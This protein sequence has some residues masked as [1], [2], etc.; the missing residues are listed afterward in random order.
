M[1]DLTLIL[2]HLVI[3]IAALVA[4]AHRHPTFNQRVTMTQLSWLLALAP[5]SAFILL[6]LR[7]PQINAGEVLVW[8]WNW[9]P[10]LG[11]T[12]GFYIDSL[13][14]FFA[15]IVTFIGTLIVLYT[16]Y[17]FKGDQK[18]WRFHVYMLLFMVSM[19]GV[20][21]AGDV[22]TLF[23]FWEGTSI[24][25][26]LLVAYKYYDEEARRGAFRALL[27]T[28]GGGIALIAGLLMVAYV[29]G[30]S[31]FPTI[32]R[33]GD[34]LRASELYLVMLGLVAFGAF[35]KSAQWPAHIWLPGAMSAPTPASAFLHSATMV[36]AGIYLMARMNPALG[37]TDAWFWLLTIVGGITMVVGAYLGL[38]QNDLKGLL[39]YSTISQLG[40]L[41]MLIGQEIP[42]AYKALVVGILAHAMYKSAL[43]LVAGTIDHETGTRDMRRL[44]GLHTAMPYSFAIATL[45]AL[46]MAGLPPMFGFLA[47]E[48]LLITTLQPSIPA[49]VA[50]IVRVASVAAGALMLAQAAF[51]IWETFLGKAKDPKIHGHEAPWGM[52]LA[53]AVPAV[54]SLVFSI[55][56]GPKEDATLLAGAAAAA[57]GDKVKVSTVLFHGLTVELMLSII[58]I[59][60]GFILFYFRHPVRAWQKALLPSLSFEAAYRGYLALIDKGS[61]YA[62]R[63]QHGKLRAYLL[64]MVASSVL[65][66]TVFSWENRALITLPAVSW[67]DLD[68][69]GEILG[70]RLF[71][72][73]LIVV[74]SSMT[75]LLV[76]D[77]DAILA[78]SVSGFSVALLFVLEQAPDVA[79]VQVVVDILALV[80]LV[81]ALTRLPRQQRRK[82][83]ELSVMVRQNRQNLLRDALVAVAI[84][85]VV[86]IITLSALLDRPR[87]SLLTPFY[88]SQAAD[89]VGASDIV[90]A[91]LV[92]FR[93]LDTLLEIV[94][95]GVAGMGIYSLLRFAAQKHGDRTDEEKK[96][97]VTSVSNLR[98]RG[99]A[100]LRASPFVRVPTF[101]SLPISMLLGATHMMYGHERPG[102]GFTAGVI[103]SLAVA[104]WFVVFGYEETRRRLPWLRAT[105]F[106]GAGVMLAIITGSVAAFMEGSFLA[107]VEFFKGSVLL[108]RGLHISSSFLFEVAIC[109]TVLGSA[110]RM[111]ISLGHPEQRNGV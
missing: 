51:L 14:L 33:S 32:L 91:I 29:A 86:T 84:G 99:I 56:P 2:P 24:L 46:S 43:F 104:L 109:L 52:L 67:P 6:Y 13:S 60:L 70:L 76:R 21:T 61:Y 81:L 19:L 64:I 93:A 105:V 68:F 94:V 73:L 85:A 48:T 74:T 66:V 38:K 50:P 12:L 27:L 35:T 98:L 90:S 30:A 89:A 107:H 41:M 4:L 110:A 9:L 63:L 100:G 106:I 79:L 101:V 92:D 40:V 55:L 10:S 62:T 80:I 71:S 53:P 17:Y 16:G 34:A 36:K 18:A 69:T 58:A 26:Y 47:K 49:L 8:Q 37:F 96:T 87:E 45:A 77:F 75:I 111:L 22:L 31:D 1:N 3:F 103:I 59:S 15:M 11:L 88:T 39:A 54:L 82:A 25:S 102:D 5:L 65:L 28:G 108:P 72:L 83:Q 95:F 78:L 97:N 23:I 44:G 20:V 42:E 7:E 57:F